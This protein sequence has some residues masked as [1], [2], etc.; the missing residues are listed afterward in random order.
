[1]T[2]RDGLTGRAHFKI[3][4]ISQQHRKLK[5][6]LKKPKSEELNK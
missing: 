5:L 2:L 6:M 4:P 3:T 1:M